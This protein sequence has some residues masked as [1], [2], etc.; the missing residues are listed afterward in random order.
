MPRAWGGGD[1]AASDRPA[2]VVYDELRRIARHYMLPWQ[3]GG[4]VPRLAMVP[5]FA[6]HGGRA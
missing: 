3:V 5:P 6:F 4:Q 1:K 2:L